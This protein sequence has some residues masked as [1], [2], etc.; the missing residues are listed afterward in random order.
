MFPHIV[1][2]V[3]PRDLYV[4][5]SLDLPIQGAEVLA[6]LEDLDT[7]RGDHA[8]ALREL[9]EE[10]DKEVKDLK[11]EIA[12]LKVSDE[13]NDAEIAKLN[14]KI[15]ALTD[16]RASFSEYERLERDRDALA[17]ECN[18]LRAERD[19]IAMSSQT[20]TSTKLS[21][22]ILETAERQRIEN[23]RLLAEVQ[24]LTAGVQRLTRAQR[25]KVGL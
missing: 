1:G 10:Y 21:S 6:L 17:V 9:T 7:A 12:D 5:A 22:F 4:R 20:W 19:A 14:E 15:E 3:N 13:W 23:E 2:N 24:R 16:P 11:E 18:A 25:A 8:E